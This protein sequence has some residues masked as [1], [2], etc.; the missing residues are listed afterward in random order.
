MKIALVHDYLTQRGGAE[1]VFELFCQRFPHA[2]IFTAIYDPEQTIQL[3]S[4]AVQTSPLQNL[5]SA[6]KYC[7]LLTSFCYPAFRS[8]DL[9]DYDL[10]LSAPLVS[11]KPSASEPMLTISAC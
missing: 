7:R 5:L 4:R 6:A 10:I 1:R 3:G 8:L 2:D 9:Q 11:Q